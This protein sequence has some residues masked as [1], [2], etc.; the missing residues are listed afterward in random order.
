MLVFMSVTHATNTNRN[1]GETASA[2]MGR[3]TLVFRYAVKYPQC[4]LTRA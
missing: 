4:L 1:E 2:C 3:K